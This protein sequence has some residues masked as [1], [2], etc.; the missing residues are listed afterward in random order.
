MVVG[1]DQE[2]SRLSGSRGCERGLHALVELKVSAPDQ[3]GDP[4]RDVDSRDA[5]SRYPGS[6]RAR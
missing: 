4:A 5:F 3:D 6:F 1:S 2:S